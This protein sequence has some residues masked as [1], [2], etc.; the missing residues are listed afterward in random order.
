[1]NGH[2]PM[3]GFFPAK[4]SQDGGL[5]LFLNAGDPPLDQ[6]KEL[7]FVLEEMGVDCLELAIPFPNSITDGATVKRSAT[8]ALQ[9]GVGLPEVLD[10]VGAV[11]PLLRRLRIVVLADWNYTVRPPGLRAALSGIADSGADAVL[12]HALPPRFHVDYHEIAASLALPVVTTCYATSNDAVKDQALRHASAYLYLVAQYGRSGSGPANGYAHLSETIQTLRRRR[13][14]P[15][16]VGF[17]VATR[18]DLDAIRNAGADAAIVGSAFISEI[19]PL[20]IEGHSTLDGAR[21]FLSRLTEVTTTTPSVAPMK[22]P[23]P[24]TQ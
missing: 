12:V 5:V 8:R 17:G 24:L 22:C 19:E 15:I 21:A 7:V 4:W 23:L 16:A 1:M 9:N 13:D 2:P 3:R 20:L 6:L 10:F 14:V 18:A 11:R